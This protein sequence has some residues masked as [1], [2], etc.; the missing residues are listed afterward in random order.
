[1]CRPNASTA[2]I[3]AFENVAI[4]TELSLLERDRH[5]RIIRQRELDFR[6]GPALRTSL[7]AR[8]RRWLN[9][10]LDLPRPLGL[11]RGSTTY[12]KPHGRARILKRR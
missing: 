7:V 2:W 4:P 10:R 3:A 1:M 5:G 9:L 11:P 12:P 8:V 6:D